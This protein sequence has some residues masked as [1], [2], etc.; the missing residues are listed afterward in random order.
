MKNIFLDL[1]S[2]GYN[3]FRTKKK[4]SF[5]KVINLCS[6]ILSTKDDAIG[7]YNS[8]KNARSLSITH[9]LKHKV[10]WWPTLEVSQV[11]V[12]VIQQWFKY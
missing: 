3:Y 4:S 5:A 12:Q 9:C 1:V 10:K 6:F 7:L 8:T 11:N 2:Q